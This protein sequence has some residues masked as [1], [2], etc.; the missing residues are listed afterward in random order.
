MSWSV[1]VSFKVKKRFCVLNLM[2]WIVLFL[3]LRN[4]EWN[5]VLRLFMMR[6]ELGFICEI[7]WVICLSLF[8][9]F[10]FNLDFGFVV[11]IVF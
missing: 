4:G 7:C 6:L 2:I 10:L 3:F 11:F 9:R 5:F 8:K 1:F